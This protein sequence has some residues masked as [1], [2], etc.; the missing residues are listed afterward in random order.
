[1]LRQLQA[2]DILA[3]IIDKH[4]Q[5][6]RQSEDSPL[7]PMPY[8]RLLKETVSLLPATLPVGTDE[9]NDYQIRSAIAAIHR[10]HLEAYVALARRGIGISPAE[11]QQE[12]AS[13]EISTELQD[14]LGSSTRPTPMKPSGAARLGGDFGS[15]AP[16]TRS[17]DQAAIDALSGKT[18]GRAFGVASTGVPL[19][20]RRPGSDVVETT[21]PRTLALPA[22]VPGS[23]PLRASPAGNAKEITPSPE[24]ISRV[25]TVLNVG[26]ETAEQVITGRISASDIRRTSIVPHEQAELVGG[27]TVND[28]RWASFYYG[29]NRSFTE[30]MVDSR[31]A[32]EFQ[33]GGGRYDR[34][35]RRV[36]QDFDMRTRGDI[37]RRVNSNNDR[38]LDRRNDVRSNY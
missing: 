3:R 10:G 21:D 36:N 7:L 26:F 8:D 22:D 15:G 6:E 35:D 24:E 13:T 28:P 5:Q 29:P 19:D 1:L 11:I 2:S 23:V 33:S 4:V 20:A 31:E 34:S 16:V 25:A 37:D 38:R 17:P 14:Y 12:A 18:S 32:F 9:L 27:L 30:L